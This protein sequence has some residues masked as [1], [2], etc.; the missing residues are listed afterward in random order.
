MLV[1]QIH[2]KIVDSTFMN[3]GFECKWNNTSEKVGN[4]DLKLVQ[5]QNYYKQ[6]KLKCR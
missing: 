6:K 2:R 3:V 1:Q 4:T 5:N